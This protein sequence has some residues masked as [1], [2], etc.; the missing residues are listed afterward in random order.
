MFDAFDVVRADSLPLLTVSDSGLWVSEGFLDEI[1]SYLLKKHV[2]PFS[3]TE[4][5]TSACIL[6]SF[7]SSSTE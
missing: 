4:L 3:N 2:T 7:I 1:M 6:K 5:I